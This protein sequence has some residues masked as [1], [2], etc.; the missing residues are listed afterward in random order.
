MSKKREHERAIFKAFLE[1]A[2]DFAGEPLADWDQP[3]QENDFP[4]IVGHG[5]SGRLIG[6]ELG[7]WLNEEQLGAAK[8]KERTEESFLEAIGDQGPN[9]TENIRY[10]WL[11]PHP[12]ARIRPGDGPDF[13]E[14]LFACIRACDRR[15]PNER[16]WRPG[17]QLGGDE[18][19]E[20]PMLSKYLSAIKF[21]P[22]DGRGK[23]ERNWI[24]FP[25]RGGAF[26]HETMWTPLRE[27]V[28]EKVSHYGSARTGFWSLSLV[29]F[30]NLAAIY[31]SPAETPFHSYED[32]VENLKYAMGA[33][34]GPF[35][36]V[37]LYIALVPGKV[38]RVV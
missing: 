14:Q 5:V 17:I 26:G 11:H 7:E 9:E 27:L 28:A 29:V 35:D 16:F 33:D 36:R 20:Y 15:W 34:R 38:F 3:Q 22:S 1:L 2:P 31:N 6:A 19:A 8:R 21:W 12:G 4:D 25:L 32:A 37:F 10:L 18:F 24:T 23:W 30:F 13:R